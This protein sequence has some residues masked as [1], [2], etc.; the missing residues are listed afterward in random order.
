MQVE[1]NV[2]IPAAKRAG[3]T[4]EIAGVVPDNY[5]HELDTNTRPRTDKRVRIILEDNSEVP[6]TGQFFSINGRAYILR[7]GEEAEV[8]VELL[9]VLNDAVMEVPTV[10]NDQVVGYRKRMRFPYRVVA[11]DI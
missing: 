2:P 5:D 7:A 1:N 3:K 11:R 9:N 8:P 10:I 4:A 6:P